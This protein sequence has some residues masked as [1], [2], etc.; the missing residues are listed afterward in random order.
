MIEAIDNFGITMFLGSDSAFLDHL[1]LTLTNAF[2]WAP[3]Y[4]ALLVL[5]IKNNDNMQQIGLC[6]LCGVLG[7]IISSVMA[8]VIVKPWIARLRPCN[9]PEIKYLVQ[10]AGNLRNKDFSFFSAHAA[11][12]MS[13]AVFFTLLVRSSLLSVTLMVWSLVN[14]W[15]RLYLGQHYLTDILVGLSWGIVTGI[16][17]YV[18]YLKVGKR[19]DIKKNFVSTQYTSTGF[20]KLDI[21]VVMSVIGL[22]LVYAMIPII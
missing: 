1:A 6:F 21:D 7:V 13:L 16:I 20:S 3:L 4:I 22:T 14:C 18:F 8:D 19:I 11:N 10:I 5:I 17:C 2:T 12:T 15:T 9:D